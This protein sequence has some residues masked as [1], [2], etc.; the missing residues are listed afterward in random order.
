M[1]ERYD[2][3]MRLSEDGYNCAQAIACAYADITGL[4]HKD[5]FKLTEFLGGGIGRM[6]EMCG[7]LCAAFLVVSYLNSDGELAQGKTKNDTY[8]KVRAL[9]DAFVEKLGSSQCKVLLNGETPRKGMCRDKL[10]VSCENLE[11]MLEDMKL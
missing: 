5:L 4:S 2:E 1:L 7:A 6:Q 8:V 11:K 3:I 9:H 10:L